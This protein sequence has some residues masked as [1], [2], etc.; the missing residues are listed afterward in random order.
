MIHDSKSCEGKD[1]EGSGYK[2]IY[3]ENLAFTLRD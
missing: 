3:G 2:V 1:S